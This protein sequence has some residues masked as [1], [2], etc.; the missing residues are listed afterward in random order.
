MTV[1][2]EA[3]RALAGLLRTHAD[4]VRDLGNTH[5]NE[6]FSMQWL[7]SSAEAFTART[8]SD[9]IAVRNAAAKIEAAADALIAHADATEVAVAEAARIE[10]LGDG[11]GRRAI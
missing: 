2:P 6:A 1:D 7:S 10:A 4:E 8:I 9:N 3:I 11:P 5:R